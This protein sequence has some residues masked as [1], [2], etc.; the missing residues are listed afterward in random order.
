MNTVGIVILSILGGALL[1]ALLLGIGL[2][3]W[4][5]FESARLFRELSALLLSVQ[6]ETR[7]LLAT[8]QSEI[9][10]VNEQH[11]GR[12]KAEFDSA[13]AA[14]NT[15]RA[16]V[17]NAWVEEVRAIHGALQDHRKEIAASIEKINAEALQTAA[18]RSVD[19]VRKLEKTVEFLQKML[20]E[21]GERPGKEYGPEEYAEEEEQQS[22]T[23]RTPASQFSVGATAR[24]DREAEEEAAAEVA[25][26][27]D[28]V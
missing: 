16:D 9:K 28:T 10:A 14:L 18:A 23:F 4:K 26:A 11:A 7:A 3:L 2:L 1:L 19:A 6:T 13:R 20:L 27:L 8:S 24:L 17:R 5:A 22:G 21:A 12:M 25:E 15:L